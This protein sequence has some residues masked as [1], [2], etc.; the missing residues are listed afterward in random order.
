MASPLF[1]RLWGS[2]DVAE[3]GRRVKVFRHPVAG[4]LRMTSMSLSIDGMP[5]CRIVVC[6]PEDE[7]TARRAEAL[8]GQ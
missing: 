6:T 7:E 2:G 5:E 4:E 3:P 1:A 8:R